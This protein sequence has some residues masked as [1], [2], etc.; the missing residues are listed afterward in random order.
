MM[1]W[2]WERLMKRT[3]CSRGAWQVFA[4]VVHHA[5][6]E[7]LAWPSW[8]LLMEETNLTREGLDGAIERM[9]ASGEVWLLK[10]GTSHSSALYFIALDA[11]PKQ[12]EQHRP[13]RLSVSQ[14]DPSPASVNFVGASV[15][16]GSFQSREQ[17]EQREHSRSTVNIHCARERA[18]EETSVKGVVADRVNVHSATPRP[19]DVPGS[20]SSG[21][22]AGPAE[23]VNGQ[24]TTTLSVDLPGLPASADQEKLCVDC[25]V[26]P[27]LP[28]SRYCEAHEDLPF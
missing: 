4:C 24:A 12:L 21:V 26:R 27:R 28:N 1:P 17:S 6:D 9:L 11:E 19:D 7:R 18:H 23:G 20:V 15:N 25:H 3:S 13:Q 16:F 2:D 22:P 10:R 8:D 5:N 14:P